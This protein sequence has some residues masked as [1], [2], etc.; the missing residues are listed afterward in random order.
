[1]KENIIETI[2]TISKKE[3]LTSLEEDFCNGTLI[4]ETL[5]PFP[6]Y[7]HKTIPDKDALNPISLFL[8]TKEKYSDEQIIR[9]S[10]EVKKNFRKSFSA[11][12]GEIS[13][14]NQSSP[15]IRIKFLKDYNQVGELAKYYKEAGIQF[16][17]YKK[18]SPYE[19]IIK[20]NKYFGLKSAGEGCYFDDDESQMCYFQIPI[21]FEW[22]Q[23]EK[24]VL[25]IKR[26]TEDNK[27]DAALG[28]FIRKNCLIDMVRVYDEEINLERLQTI[29]DKFLREIKQIKKS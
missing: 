22:E 11:V 9:A 20:V 29:R 12:Q 14:F 2:G 28:T 21:K 19:G 7:Y 16:M 15:C 17:K 25:D 3:T 24:M 23:F 6:G 5:Y 8:I 10:H 1:M 26:N 18:V 4:I 27:F 13:L